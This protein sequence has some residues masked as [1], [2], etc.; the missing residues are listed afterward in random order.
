VIAFLRGMRTRSVQVAFLILLVVCSAQLAYWL[1][2]EVRYTANVQ[3]QRRFAYE[4][5][6]GAAAAMLRRGATW[7][8]A[9]AMH[10]DLVIAADSMSVSVAP[11]ALAQLDAERFHRLNRYAWEGAFFLAVLLAAMAVVLRAIREEAELRRRQENFLTAV[12]HELKTP[13]A[14]LRLSVET[15]A[16]RDPPAGRRAELVQR[17]L[18]DLDRLQRMIANILDASRLAADPV[19]TGTERV[20]LN[21]E[22]AAVIDEL[23]DLAGENDVHV[24]ADV[25]PNVVVRADH[26]GVRTIVRNLVHNAIKAASGGGHVTIVGSTAD[27]R[28]RFEVR[29]DGAGFPPRE[30]ARLFE[31]FYRVEANGRARSTGTGLGLYLV[32]RCAELDG[33]TVA[34]ESAGPGLG[35]RFTVTWPATGGHD[36]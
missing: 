26:D 27:G 36:A 10:R 18:S 23:R 30:A 33:G 13:L 28:T 2:D 34:A 19:H 24:H 8:D 32:R 31:K 11:E 14:S 20:S 22:V 5:E 29:D 21:D 25:P 1:A 16:M 4:T 6:A 3:A 9:G 12:S 7:R 17:L 15:L 35:A